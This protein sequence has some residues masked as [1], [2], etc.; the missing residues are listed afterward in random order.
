[1]SRPAI[2][3]FG[4]IVD[5]ARRDGSVHFPVE[6]V[7][8]DFVAWRRRVRQRARADALSISVIRAGGLVVVENREWE[9]SDAEDSA[10][11]DVIAGVVTGD[12]VTYDEAL[13]RRR[14]ERLRLT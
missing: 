3:D 11:A 14:R 13:Y 9:S 8:G 7:P 4:G 2:T 5:A 10:V 1:M 6:S 12:R